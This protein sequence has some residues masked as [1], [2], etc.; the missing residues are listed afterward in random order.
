M[1]EVDEY[2]LKEQFD[3]KY[4]PSYSSALG[5]LGSA[6]ITTVPLSLKT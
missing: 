3:M 5:L 1:L 4:F 2:S 6:L